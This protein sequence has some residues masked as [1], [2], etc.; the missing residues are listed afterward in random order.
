MRGSAL[1]LLGLLALAA[2]WENSKQVLVLLDNDDLRSTHS[3]FFGAVEDMGFKLDFRRS[4]DPDL[5]LEEFGVFKYDALIL[6]AP[7][8]EEFGGKVDVAGILKFI[9]S[10]R[11][12]LAAAS[13]KMADPLRELAAECG[14]EFDDD[15]AFVID[16]SN[17]DASDANGPHTLVLASDII[18]SKII[19]PDLKAP[20]LFRGI[21]QTVM[22]NNPLVL[23]IL[24][25]SP[26]AYTYVQSKSVKEAPLATGKDTLLVS[27]LQA[28]NNARVTFSGSL[29][30]FS[31]RFFSS[32]VQRFNAD[33]KIE[34]L[35]RSGNQ[36]FAVEVARWTLQEKGMLRATNVRHRIVNGTENPEI[37]RIKDSL[38]YK[39]DIMEYKDGKWIPF[40]ADDVQLEFTMLDPYVRTTL[41]HNGKGTYS[42]TFQ[43]PDVYGV[44]KL[45]LHYRRVGYST[46]SAS[47]QVAVRPFDHNEY[48]RFIVSA[49]PYYASAFSMMV[50]MVL[51]SIVFLFNKS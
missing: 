25:A 48:E 6:F 35:S 34:T 31:N 26:T 2:A 5:V 11:D 30:L 36:Q 42:T 46:L 24:T 44:F 43:V 37:Y 28:R 47:H 7:S 21:G 22:D 4:N 41:Q 51:F 13:P 18:K 19:V 8:T 49:Y 20:V 32:P 45:V 40:V 17:Y 3:M 50:G 29:E 9:D 23:R 12:V 1:F 33:G 27:A 15:N 38:E 39:V 14:I 16:H 10:G